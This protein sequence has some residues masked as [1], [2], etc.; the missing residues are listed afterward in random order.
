LTYTAECEIVELQ[1]IVARSVMAGDDAYQIV[2]ADCMRGN[3]ALVSDGSLLDLF[4]V[5]Y[6]DLSREYWNQSAPKIL[7]ING[8]LFFAKSKYV[9]PSVPVV[10]FNKHMIEDYGLTSPY[11]AVRNG[12]WTLDEFISGIRK[13]SFDL[14]GDGKMTMADQYGLVCMSDWPLDCM[15][16]AAGINITLLNAEGRMELSILSERTLSLYEKLYNLLNVGD[17]TFHWAWGTP[18]EKT[19]TMASDRALFELRRSNALHELRG[20]EIDFGI[21]PYPKF[22]ETQADYSINDY[23]RNVCIPITV[24]DPGM[25]GKTLEMLAYYSDLFVYSTYYDGLLTGK[26][27]RDRESIE[28]LEIISNSVVFDGGMTYF[29]LNGGSMQNIMY[30]ISRNIYVG[31]GD[32]VSFYER[33]ENKAKK[34]IDEFYDSIGS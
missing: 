30:F 19:I 20:S 5:E 4:Q 28:M 13:G 10:T 2:L 16:Y 9:I 15:L 24:A 34:E 3:T 31:K 12:T 33:N 27:V 23:S 8:K 26:V 17:D 6:I 29:G 21:V 1:G 7:T 32:F 22:D 18:T 11:E 14:N 25:V